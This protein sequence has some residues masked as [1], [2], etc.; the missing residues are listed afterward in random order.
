MRAGQVVTL[1]ALQSGNRAEGLAR[2]GLISLD[3][4]SLL[5][6][7]FSQIS[8]EHIAAPG[9]EPGIFGL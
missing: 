2:A 6:A 5:T 4:Q 7:G 9:L 8:R 1:P 3:L